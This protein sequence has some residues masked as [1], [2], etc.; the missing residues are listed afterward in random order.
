MVAILGGCR[1]MGIIMILSTFLVL[2]HYSSYW[3]I[4]EAQ[5][6]KFCAHFAPKFFPYLYSGIFEGN[7]WLNIWKN[8]ACF[9]SGIFHVPISDIF[10][11]PLFG[12]GY[13]NNK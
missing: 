9:S 12:F 3:T 8:L 4:C 5:S 10:I 13:Y 6:V 2:S 7:L 11:R 1:N